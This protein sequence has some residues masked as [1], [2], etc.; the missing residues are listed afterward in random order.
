MRADIGD[1]CSIDAAASVGYEHDGDA[2]PAALGDR[3]TVR[4]GTII[5]CDVEIGDDFTTGHGA[6]VREETTSGAMIADVRPNQH[7]STGSSRVQN[8]GTAP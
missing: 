1:N 2:T 3:A 8:E 4:G 6:L 7:Q 5:Y